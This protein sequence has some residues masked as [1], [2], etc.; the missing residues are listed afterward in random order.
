[1]PTTVERV[2]TLRV[3]DVS[4]GVVHEREALV[5]AAEVRSGD[6]GSPVVD[7]AGD[8]VG[9]VVL[10]RR[11]ESGSYATRVP[12]LPSRADLAADQ[13]RTTTES[14]GPSTVAV[15]RAAACT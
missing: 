10:R 15:A 1:M 9:V 11:D 14:A 4:A 2:V 6:S 12:P 5:L 8:V 7:G 3:D 13:L